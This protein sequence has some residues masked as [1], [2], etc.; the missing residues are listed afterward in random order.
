MADPT[1]YQR[2]R[3]DDRD[4]EFYARLAEQRDNRKSV[5][6]L[7]VPRIEGR[8]FTVDKGQMRCKDPERR[9]VPKPS[10]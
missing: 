7:V 1:G 8:A 10:H 2:P 9:G 5:R 6:D 4:D 3:L